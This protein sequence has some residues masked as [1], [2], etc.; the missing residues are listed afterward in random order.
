MSLV[1]LNEILDAIIVAQ[2]QHAEAGLTARELHTDEQLPA[3]LLELDAAALREYD[4]LKQLFI[5]IARQQQRERAAL[6]SA[7]AREARREIQ[8]M[9][10]R[11]LGAKKIDEPM[12]DACGICLETHTM[13]HGLHTSCGH[14]FGAACMK[15]YLEHPNSNNACPICRQ[16]KPKL[17]IYRPWATPKR[18]H[19]VTETVAPLVPASK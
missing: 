11:A 9:V 18:Q 13:R 15:S 8:R 17:T 19:K 12:G 6:A 4:A 3:I 1:I 5:A 10:Q 7:P 16:P 14:C 2:R